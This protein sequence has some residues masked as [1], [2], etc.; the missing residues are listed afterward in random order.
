MVHVEEELA[1]QV[2]EVDGIEVDN[3][4]LSKACQHQVLQKLTPDSPR[5]NHQYFCLATTLVSK[6]YQEQIQSYI[7]DLVR[8]CAAQSLLY[9]H[10]P[11]HLRSHC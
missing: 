3:V 5:S 9:G 4:D 7:F 8:Q 10:F 1:I 11:A 6:E 2:A